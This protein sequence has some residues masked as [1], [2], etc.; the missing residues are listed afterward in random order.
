MDNNQK[1]LIFLGI[2]LAIGLSIAGYFIS[3]T[4]YNSK[5]ALNT[6]EAKGLAERRVRA[7]TATWELVFS[8]TGKSKG[9]L[10]KLYAEA[11]Q[12]QKVII[13][14]LKEKGFK[15]SEIEIGVIDY[16]P[17]EYRD[18]KQNLVDQKHSLIGSIVVN[19]HDVELVSKVR[20]NV[21][22]L[23]AQGIDIENRAPAYLFTKLNDIK[24]EMLREATKNARVAANEFAQN[25]GVNVGGIRSA[26]QGS[27]FIK[28]A[29]NSYGDTEKIEKDVRVV[30][31]ITFYLTD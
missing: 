20:A 5:V 21:N 11:E 28:D 10:P 26:R 2:F 18:D 3:Q 16:Y 19:T 12:R 17:E 24:P 8:V 22:T 14:L 9:E 31:T 25:A 30:T 1:G 29:G 13:D 4:I 6:A 7:D 27:F 23:I 15:E